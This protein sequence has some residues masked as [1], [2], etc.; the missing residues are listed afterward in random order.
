[1]TEIDRITDPLLVATRSQEKLREIREILSTVPGIQVVDL[2]QVGIPESVEE[3]SLEV[4]ETFAEN[5]LAKARY[6]HRRS[7]LPTVADDS[8]LEV[9]ALGGRPGVRS[10]R[11]APISGHVDRETQDRVNLNH[12]LESLRGVPEPMR[13]ARFV[14]EVALVSREGSPRTFRGLV[15]GLILE[16]P[17]GNGG[18]G[19]DPLFLHPRLGA[20]FAEVSG[21][22][23]AR[24]GHRGAAF[25]RLATFL[26]ETVA[27]GASVGD[28]RDR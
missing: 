24:V 8:G 12:L 10:R 9:D 21:E 27:R 5:A 4:A 20:T 22:E 26:S 28:E 13:T 7:G 11:F 2:L 23:K 17:R 16:A 19:Y 18:F 25:R 15:D 6:F 3:E 14:T 1:M